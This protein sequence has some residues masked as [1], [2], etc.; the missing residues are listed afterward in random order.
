MKRYLKLFFLS[1]VVPLALS[2]MNYENGGAHFKEDCSALKKMDL[3]EAALDELMYA[4]LR[5]NN[6]R[7]ANPF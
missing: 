7:H 5:E 6:F 2:A 4:Y 3:P 1:T